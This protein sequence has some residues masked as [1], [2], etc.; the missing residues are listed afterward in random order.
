MR[1]RVSEDARE[2]APLRVL[3][4]DDERLARV[5]LEDLVRRE[6]GVE[7][8][9]TARSGALAV[10][11]IR[12]L[13]PDLVFLDVQ[14][15]VMTGLDVA[16]EI[17]PAAMPATIFVT[18]F[19]KYA[20]QAFDV[21]AVDYLVKPFGDERFQQAFRRAR[22]QVA[23]GEIERQRQ[24]LLNALS[25]LASNPRYLE[26]VAIETRGKVRSVP[27][28]EIDYIAASGSYAELHVDGRRY[29]IRERMQV[30]EERLDPTQFMRVHRSVIVRLTMVELLHRSPGGDYEVQLR[31]GVRLPVSRARHEALERWLGIAR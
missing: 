6:P 2:A 28:A 23:L 22:R 4:V 8:V 13:R 5:R 12:A 3:I 10:E 31:S 19:E 29:L 16:R 26:R 1:R 11:A 18:A 17:G 24:Q 25:T 9:G 21:A 30:L 7:L 27:V 14:M 20:L 15:P